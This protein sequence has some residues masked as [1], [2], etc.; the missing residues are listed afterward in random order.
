MRNYDHFRIFMET[1]KYK[2]RFN[3]P[4]H[5]NCSLY[6]NRYRASNEFGSFRIFHEKSLFLSWSRQSLDSEAKAGKIVRIFHFQPFLLLSS[7]SAR[8]STAAEKNLNQKM[9]KLRSQRGSIDPRSCSE[10]PFFPISRDALKRGQT[11]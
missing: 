6:W 3:F 1:V 5:L 8:S 10:A 7:P 11:D 9:K 4:L 2:A